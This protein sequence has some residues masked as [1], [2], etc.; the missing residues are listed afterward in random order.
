M[1]VAG[2]GITVSCVL[3]IV[4]DALFTTET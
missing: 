3:L 2:T 4:V 1:T